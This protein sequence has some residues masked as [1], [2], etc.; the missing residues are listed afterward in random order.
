MLRTLDQ[1]LDEDAE[2]KA[3]AFFAGEDVDDDITNGGGATDEVIGRLQR[4]YAELTLMEEGEEGDTARDDA[5]D[6][7]QGSG[8]ANEA[9]THA[10]KKEKRSKKGR[11]K[12]ATRGSEAVEEGIYEQDANVELWLDDTVAETAV[13]TTTSTSIPTMSAPASVTGP[14]LGVVGAS[15]A[16]RDRARKRAKMTKRAEGDLRAV[17]LEH[18]QIHRGITYEEMADAEGDEMRVEP[19][20]AGLAF[21]VEAE[22]ELGLGA[23]DD[24]CGTNVSM[25]ASAGAGESGGG[26]IGYEVGTG[27]GGDVS[28]ED[29][30]HSMPATATGRGF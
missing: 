7:Q 8:Q 19:G 22:T 30:A 3:M 23:G 20:E 13:P 25:S 1:I 12:K 26:G 11:K 17:A 28:M 10:Q 14:G 9:Q 27:G 16:D 2:R 24:D 18:A 21:Q 29:T 15:F 6:G 4:R 5:G